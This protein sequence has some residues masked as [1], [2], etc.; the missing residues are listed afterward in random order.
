MTGIAVQRSRTALPGRHVDPSSPVGRI[1]KRLN[2]TAFAQ[3]M[4]II[5]LVLIIWPTSLGGR[6]GIVMVAGNS[7]EPTYMLG[8]AVVTWREPVEI[9]D[10]ALF[11]VPE[12]EVGAGNPV[13][14]RVIG[15]DADGWITKGDN[16]SSADRWKPSNREV[17][18]V[19]K[20]HIPVGGRFIAVLR[21][22]LV[23]AV[24]GGLMVG[25]MAW[26]KDT[27]NVESTHPKRGRHRTRRFSR[28]RL[29]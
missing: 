6:L 5:C 2:P 13:V 17:L 27:Q 22:W 16:T 11:R 18:G 14:H 21:S 1:T 19:V 20:L 8:D 3:I 12:G 7:M 10:T 29:A 15:G 4:M 25:L 26:P 24:L 28:A 23:I 9:G